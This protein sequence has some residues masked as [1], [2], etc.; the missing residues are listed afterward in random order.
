VRVGSNDLGFVQALAPAGETV[1]AKDLISGYRRLIAAAHRRGVGIIGSTVP[2]FG[3]VSVIPGY[4][5]PAKEAVRRQVNEWIRRGGEFDAVLDFDE[6][7]RD[8][9]DPAK[10]LPAYDSGD[11]LHPNDAGYRAVASALPLNTLD[12]L[13]SSARVPAETS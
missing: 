6:I 2:P 11:H 9:S 3:N 13:A 1:D 7:L 12:R 4:S 5:S 8:P 10:L